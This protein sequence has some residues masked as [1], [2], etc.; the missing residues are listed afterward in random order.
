MLGFSGLLANEYEKYNVVEQKKFIGIIHRKLHETYKLLE[1]LLLW[2]RSQK[3]TINYNPETEN[4][5]LIS[6]NIIQLLRLASDN[7]SIKIVNDISEDIFVM[8]DKNM[9]STIIRNLLSNAIKFTPKNGEVRISAKI[10]PDSN[11][12]L[13]E[14]T[15]QDNGVGISA[16]IQSKLFE[17]G[18]NI[19]TKGTENEAGSGLGLLLCKEFVEKHNC[20]IWIESE[21]GVG[22]KFIFTI[23]SA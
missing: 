13:V 7:K 14:V 19:S 23:P 22:S 2:S 9:L 18:E 21:V 20:E 17:I 11:Q 8:V 10:L 3:G 16:E 1:N 15:I 5:F 4:L 12:K 6:K